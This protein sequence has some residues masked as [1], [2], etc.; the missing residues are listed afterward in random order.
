MLKTIRVILA[1]FFF[2]CITFLFLDFR[3]TGSEW[4]DFFKLTQIIPAIFAGAVVSIIVLV[5]LTLVFGRIYCSVICPLG[6][7]QDFMSK[8]YSWFLP[9]KKRHARFKYSQGFPWFRY[10]VFAFFFVA[11]FI[12]VI[13]VGV[14]AWASLI[15]PYSVYGRIA[16]SLFSPFYDMG[17]NFL[18]DHSVSQNN[19]TFWHIEAHNFEGLVFW[20][21]IVTFI[22]LSIAVIAAGRIWCNTIC[23]AGSLLGFFSRYSL[24]SPRI[25]ESKCVGCRKCER[26][27]KAQCIDIKNRKI[28]YS[29]CITCFN[30][31]GR[32]KFGALK[33][34]LR[35]KSIGMPESEK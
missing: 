30:C 24:F 25:S 12:G 7:L 4:Y 9:G 2:C 14:R 15:E 13:H 23:P 1:I 20:I 11:M 29:R 32:C 26:D 28:D 19:T 5:V 34:S 10:I 8:L 3:N 16:H 6:V 35:S 22:I 27:C 31:L 17:N 21:S 33:Y 18:A